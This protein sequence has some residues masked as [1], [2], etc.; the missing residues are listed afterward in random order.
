MQA[1]HVNTSAKTVDLAEMKNRRTTCAANGEADVLKPS[2]HLMNLA[3][4]ALKLIV[5]ELGICGLGH[6]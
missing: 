1:E 5:Q 2:K 6:S 3:T 4:W